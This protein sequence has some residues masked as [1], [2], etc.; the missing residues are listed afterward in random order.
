M[1]IHVCG[2]E[3]HIKF[4]TEFLLPNTELED[5]AIKNA[6]MQILHNISLSFTITQDDITVIRNH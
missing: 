1:C 6:F 2:S 3:P 5:A 4:T